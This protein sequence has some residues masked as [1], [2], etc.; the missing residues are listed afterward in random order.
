MV[1]C[2][3]AAWLHHFR[4]HP[5]YKKTY[6]LNRTSVMLQCE[7]PTFDSKVPIS[8]SK[9]IPNYP[10]LFLQSLQDQIFTCH[11]R[12]TPVGQAKRV[13]VLVPGT[14]TP[15]DCVTDLKALP[16][17]VLADGRCAA[18][19]QRKDDYGVENSWI[20]RILMFFFE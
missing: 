7:I 14:Q 11:P 4:R 5:T 12:S 8:N 19:V 20:G 2:G 18:M 3:L 1:S 13:A 10:P 17:K 15:Q 6:G 9:S 16:V